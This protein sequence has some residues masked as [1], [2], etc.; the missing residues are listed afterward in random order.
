MQPA[1]NLVR[2]AKQQGR[3]SQPE[4]RFLSQSRCGPIY[5]LLPLGVTVVTGL[6]N[7]WSVRGVAP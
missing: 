6:L 3:L 7:L 4:L 2:S 1:Q 5:T